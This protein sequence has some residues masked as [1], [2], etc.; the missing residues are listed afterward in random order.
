[1][2]SANIPSAQLA[3]AELAGD[4]GS[5]STG[6]GGAEERADQLPR[7]EDPQ[8]RSPTRDADRRRRRE[9]RR[10]HRHNARHPRLGGEGVEDGEREERQ[11]AD[12]NVLA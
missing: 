11:R 10:E 2:H 3:P 4:R 9:G 1:V 8:R 6:I 7:A 12:L 5:G